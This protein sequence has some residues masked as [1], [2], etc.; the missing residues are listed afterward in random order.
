MVGLTMDDKTKTPTKGI[1]DW[2]T[3]RIEPMPGILELLA[4]Q[5]S[6]GYSSLP[7]Q[8]L[9]SHMQQLYSPMDV[10]DTRPEDIR[11]QQVPGQPM[12]NAPTKPVVQQQ[13]TEMD[14]LAQQREAMRTGGWR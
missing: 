9:L 11:N 8:G 7:Q 10:F 2:P 4:K 12:P 1:L 3:R 6:T 5:L 14:W 13:P